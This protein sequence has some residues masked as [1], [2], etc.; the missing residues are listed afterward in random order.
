MRDLV[1][2]GL[3]AVRYRLVRCRIHDR[4]DS[5]LLPTGFILIEGF[6]IIGKQG[7]ADKHPFVG[8]EVTVNSKLFGQLCND[9][10]RSM[11]HEEVVL[12][13][14]VAGN[15]GARLFHRRIFIVRHF[16]KLD[17]LLCCS[18]DGIDRLR[19]TRS[20]NST[21]MRDDGPV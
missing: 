10:S 12:R 13:R 4:T 17:L 6:G 1:Y 19:W 5:L 20:S 9:F 16:D 14:C 21:E 18:H 3:V 2:Q 11:T 8:S 15:R 7:A